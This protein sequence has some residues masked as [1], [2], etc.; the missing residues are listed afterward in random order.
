MKKII[1]LLGMY[2]GFSVFAQDVWVSDEIEAPLREAPELNAKIISLLPAGERVTALDQNK[3]Y[4]KVKTAKGVQGWLSNYYVL[5]SQSIH[6]KFSPMEKSLQTLQQK[7]KQL[8]NDLTEKEQ[9][10]K[11]LQTAVGNAKKTSSEVAERAKTSESDVAKLSS[12][13]ALLEKKLNEQSQ[14]MTQLAT[15][16][17]AAK[18]KASD[19][20]TRYLRLVKV[21]ENAVDIDKQNSSL[22][23]KAVQ[24][25]RELQQLKNE[26]QSLKAKLDTRQAVIT[27]MLIFGGILVGYV[28]SVLM[29]PRNRRHA[30]SYSSL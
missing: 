15:A 14:K 13:N 4:V 10:I 29:P 21:S 26:N 23:E 16:L 17:D 24:F 7:N 2:A 20:R 30:S 11:Q 19:A 22:Q 5:R 3:D 27:A 6:D 18:Q 9:Q 25:E 28:L 8:E 12:D 1:L